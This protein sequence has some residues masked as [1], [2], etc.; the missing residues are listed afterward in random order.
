MQNI[1]WRALKQI[2]P[3]KKEK[4]RKRKEKKESYRDCA[5]LLWNQEISLNSSLLPSGKKKKCRNVSGTAGYWMIKKIKDWNYSYICLSMWKWKHRFSWRNL[6]DPIYNWVSMTGVISANIL[7]P[8]SP[9]SSF[10]DVSMEA[11][12]F[13]WWN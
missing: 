7:I 10:D 8:Y 9:V 1:P 11:F 13:T 6:A 12:E 5:T 4:K 3:I 2:F